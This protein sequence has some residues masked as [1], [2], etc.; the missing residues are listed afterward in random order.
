MSD[1]LDEYL[2]QGMYGAKQTKPDERRKFLGTIRERIVLVLTQPQVRKA[3][4][5]PQVE[6]ALKTH[7]GA[8]VYLNGNIDYSYL[9]KYVKAANKYKLEYTIVTNNE[10]NSEIGLVLAYDYAIDKEEIYVKDEGNKPV[11]KQQNVK[12]GIFAK[13][14]KVFK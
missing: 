6:E 10:H 9:S 8:S 11:L 7:Q 14:K 12:P 2:K 4:I 3:G 13:L 1:Q 5:L